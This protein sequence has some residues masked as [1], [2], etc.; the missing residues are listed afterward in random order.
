MSVSEQ[1]RSRRRIWIGSVALL[2][3]GFVLM[4]PTIVAKTPLR[5]W[6]INSAIKDDGYRVTTAG[7]SLGYVTPITIDGFELQASDQSVHVGIEQVGGDKSWLSMMMSGGDLG[8][9]IFLKPTIVMNVKASSDEPD[10]EDEVESNRLEV[11][12]KLRARVEDATVMVHSEGDPEPIIELREIAFE[13]RLEPLDQGAL[14]HLSPVTL[15][16]EVALTPELC[17]RGLQLVAPMLADVVDVSGRVS[18]RVD[19]FTLPIG[20]SDQ[21]GG[22]DP[23]ERSALADVA[24]TVTLSDVSVG[25]KGRILD[26]LLPLLG[27]LTDVQPD[28]SLSLAGSSELSFE[29]VDGRVHHDGL[30]LLLPVADTSLQLQ[31]HGSVGWMKPWTWNCNWC[32]RRPPAAKRGW[33]GR[34]WDHRYRSA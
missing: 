34:W 8:T 13:T 12:P 19:R 14:V 17:S 29:L 16:D 2:L 31:S 6:V 5:D 10:V 23:I 27:R 9:F 33:R 4:V 28:A 15:L 7:A 18:C 21:D 24:G 30:V 3:V 22:S 1:K 25:P 11:W 20:G 32:C 26:R